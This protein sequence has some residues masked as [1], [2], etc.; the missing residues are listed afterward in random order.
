MDDLAR[1]AE[2]DVKTV[3]NAERGKPIYFRTLA[4]IAKALDV[5][6]TSLVKVAKEEGEGGVAVKMMEILVITKDGVT[7]EGA[8]DAI[9]KKYSSRFKSLDE[10]KITIVR[11]GDEV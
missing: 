10:V 2:V 7:A 5:E 11:D 8:L 1:E 6:W 9:K 3:E 4:A